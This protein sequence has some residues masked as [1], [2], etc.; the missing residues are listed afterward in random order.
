MR[1][2]V[3]NPD[4]GMSSEALRKREKMLSEIARS[5]TQI[6]MDCVTETEVEIDSVVDV[7]LVGPEI[8]KR[9]IQAER[10]GYDAV[11][12]YCLSD[13]AI[14]ACRE[15]VRIPVIGG[16]QASV[17]VAASL[18]YRFSIITTSTRRIPEKIE[19]TRAM[20][21][22]PTRLASVRSVE[23]PLGDIHKNSRKTIEHLAEASRKCVHDDGA[24]VV[25]LGCLSYAGMAAEISNMV[26]VPVV[27]PAFAVINMAELLHA[28]RLTHS[29]VAYPYPPSANRRWEK[30]HVD[31]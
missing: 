24:Q 6:S 2:K 1:I 12:L 3:I 5:D 23:M 4:Y 25:I 9:A 31:L 14:V 26:G 17:L 15:A 18:G 13:P 8:I 30:G 16:G 11:V 19:S 7:T 29:K 22:D 27:D 28:Q 10:E 21:V 20:G